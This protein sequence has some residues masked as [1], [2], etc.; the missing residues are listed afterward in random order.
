MEDQTAAILAPGEEPGTVSGAIVT[1]GEAQQHMPLNRDQILKADDLGQEWV[2]V[3]E[4]GGEVLIRT[5]SGKE[6]DAF[7]ASCR[8]ERPVLDAR[9]KPI[10]GRTEM[11]SNQDNV[12]A[13]LVARSI[14]DDQGNRLFT[15]QDVNALGKKSAAALDR[16]FEVAAR[17]SRLSE[18]DI[19]VMSGEYEA[20]QSGDS[21]TS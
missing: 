14:V 9:G 2:P 10:R 5:L 21:S 6:R 7:E 16:V 20:A 18:D 11:V 17:L 3:A 1:A 12:R 8:Q 4:W 13:K 15:D 19:E